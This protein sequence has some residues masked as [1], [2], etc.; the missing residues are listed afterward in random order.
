MSTDNL[1]VIL[2]HSTSEPGAKM[3]I[4]FA[5]NHFITMLENGRT[6]PMTSM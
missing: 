5:V 3:V 1:L 2:R 4:D 6:M